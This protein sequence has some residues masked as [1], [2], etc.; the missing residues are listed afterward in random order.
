MWNSLTSEVLIGAGGWDYFSVPGDRL[1]NYARAFRTVEVNST[2][3]VI[4]PLQEVESWKR[5]AP[6]GFEF[7]VRC[8]HALI[9]LLQSEPIDQPL[10]IFERMKQ[11]CSILHASILHIQTPQTLQLSK[12]IIK[13][14]DDFLNHI[15]VELGVDLEG[16]IPFTK[17]AIDWS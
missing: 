1:R 15:S 9:H 11:I 6:E 5:R 12:E 13:K 16:S 14:L 10:E 2:Y 3:Y 8:N 7:T 4:P 17:D